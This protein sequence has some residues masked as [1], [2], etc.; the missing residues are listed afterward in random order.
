MSGDL[1][2]LSVLLVD[3]NPHMM[4]LVRTMLRGFGITQTTECRDPAEALEIARL[5]PVDVIIIDYQMDMI[6]GVEFTRLVRTGR[7]SRNPYVPIVMLSAY[8]ERSRIF[9]A[10]DAGV[11]EFCA[12]PVNA[13][14]L[15][16]KLAA[17]IN[18]PRPF[19]RTKRYFGP[20][21]RR[22]DPAEYDGE[23]R[24]SDEDDAANAAAE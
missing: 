4:H 23:E 9:A 8:T 24:R 14:Q 21:R 10:R 2:R 17:V 19:V 16:L 18:H 12:K 6:D 3:D 15:W 5:E 13:E 1:G 7:D 11:T 22:R 20:D